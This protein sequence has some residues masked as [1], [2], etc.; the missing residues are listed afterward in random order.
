MTC[1][2]VDRYTCSKA[3]AKLEAP[4]HIALSERSEVRCIF[5]KKNYFLTL[6]FL[7]LLCP[8]TQVP[9]FRRKKNHRRHFVLSPYPAHC[10]ALFFFLPVF[11]EKC[12]LSGKDV[13]YCTRFIQ[14]KGQSAR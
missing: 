10:S 4:P 7:A 2:A 13:H 6:R 5:A 8:R 14:M 12:S 3:K 1:T 9:L 11:T